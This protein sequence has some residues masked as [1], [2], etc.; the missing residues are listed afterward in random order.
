MN[1]AVTAAEKAAILAH[2]SPMSA[3]AIQAQRDREAAEYALDTLLADGD[4]ETVQCIEDIAAD[5]AEHGVLTNT[6]A[7]TDWLADA[8]NNDYGPHNDIGGMRCLDITECSD[9]PTLMALVMAG[10]A[11]QIINAA[12]RLRDLLRADW[13]GVIAED[14]R[15]IVNKFQRGLD[16]LARGDE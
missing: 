3:V 16:V 14:A 4:D 13:A 2:Y 15:N 10:N 7:V 8:C 6:A 5:E 1:T 11:S 9:I 12:M